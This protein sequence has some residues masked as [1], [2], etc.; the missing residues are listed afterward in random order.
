[1]H[2]D[3]A[4]H[5]CCLS[6]VSRR[7]FMAATGAACLAPRGAAPA[8]AGDLGEYIDLASFRPRPPVKIVS[9][10]AR[11]TP[12]YWLGWPGT[13]YD[14]EGE[15]A[16]YGRI[17]AD[18]ARKTGVDLAA[19][20]KPLESD[21]DVNA[22]VEK[23]KAAKPHAVLV[24]LQ[25]FGVWH[26]ADAISKA[27]IPTIIFSPIGMAF[28]GHVRD[29]SRRPG[30]H[31]IS[32]LD[33]NAVAQAFRM[34]RAKE[35]F[36][37]TQ[38]LVVAGGERKENVLE[39]LDTK[40]KYV[41]R[42]SLHELFARMPVTDE[43]REVAAALRKNAR[44]V[45]E[46]KPDDF[47][48]SARSYTTAKRLMRMEGANAI[49]TDCLGMVSSRAVP[50]PPC[51]GVSMFLDAGVTYGCEADLNG[52][53]G[54]LFVSYL[55]DKSGFMNDPVPE[56]RRNTLIA[57]H[58][59]CGTKLNGFSEGPEPY[60]ARSHSESNIGVCPQVLWREHMHV[61]MVNFRGP[62]ELILDTG[63]VVGNIDTPPAGGCRTSVE[64]AMDRVRDCRD[65]LGFHQMVFY[66]DHRR[67]VEAFCQ[68]Y[69]IKVV[70]SD[71]QA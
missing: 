52:A 20:E 70:N 4:S 28:T 7:S 27:G 30:I 59:S 68:L 54:L 17:F 32:S 10:V 40:V 13:A 41:P 56:T 15:R 12:P 31:V 3:F 44:A 8:D 65:V 24:M 43:V 18:I 63:K 34:I 5:A 53:L 16:R 46:P 60:I 25:H 23:V 50:T 48:N 6:G 71:A 35:Q 49:T 42:A 67:D 14:V 29:I 55:F 64:L 22:F 45:V 66:G 47:L 1:M 37:A 58:C 57:A 69:G 62:R 33:T 11:H 51:M 21:A 19:E 36:A 39:L 61:T 38:L 26:W 9:A 2:R